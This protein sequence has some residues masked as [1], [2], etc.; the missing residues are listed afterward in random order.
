M[1]FSHLF[2]PISNI[3]LSKETLQYKETY[4]EGTSYFYYTRHLGSET[5][6]TWDT[7]QLPKD[8]LPHIQY[9]FVIK[10]KKKKKKIK[11]MSKSTGKNLYSSQKK[12]K[13]KFLSQP[14][15][16]L[17][18]TVLYISTIEIQKW[19]TLWRLYL[20]DRKIERSSTAFYTTV[21][22]ST[23]E[24]TPDPAL[25]LSLSTSSQQTNLSVYFFSLYFPKKTFLPPHF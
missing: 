17:N 23:G 2:F 10:R 25:T 16:P 1:Q 19:S 4:E 9:C 11:K 24:E 7:K 13:K 8:R 22:Q 6:L 14:S 20:Q 15:L 12:K 5:T 3:F 18:V 21:L